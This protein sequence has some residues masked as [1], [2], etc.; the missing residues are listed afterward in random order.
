MEKENSYCCYHNVILNLFK[1]KNNFESLDKNKQN[2]LDLS[3]QVEKNLVSS[4]EILLDDLEDDKNLVCMIKK[5]IKYIIIE[6]M[7]IE[8]SEFF[9]V[10]YFKF[11]KIAETNTD[12]GSVNIK[13][14]GLKLYFDNKKTDIDFSKE[15]FVFTGKLKNIDKFNNSILEKQISNY[16]LIFIY[17]Y[18]FMIFPT[19]YESHLLTNKLLLTNNEYFLNNYEKAFIGILAS[20]AIKCHYLYNLLGNIFFLE[21]GER[22]WLEHGIVIIP[23]RIKK[24][25]LINS[26][27]CNNPWNINKENIKELM[28]ND[29]LVS[30]GWSNHSELLNAILILTH[31]QKIGLI[32]NNL[33][34]EFSKTSFTQETEEFVLS[35]SFRPCD[36][37]T[38]RINFLKTALLQ[39]SLNKEKIDEELEQDDVNSTSHDDKREEGICE[40]IYFF[41]RK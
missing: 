37:K 18:F 17:E 35:P 11:F 8:I 25:A 13:F 31:Y 26:L 20:S 2:T 24:L 40:G 27:L 10:L 23:K 28:E 33:E 12:Y 30:S 21:G 4:I 38:K 5:T 19:Y 29:S 22:S 3:N 7:F 1:L 32:V 39:L 41:L 15:K 9:R 16:S 36:K 6:T 34:I 14:D